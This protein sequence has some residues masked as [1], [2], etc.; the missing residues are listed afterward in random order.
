MQAEEKAKISSV[1]DLLNT[2]LQMDREGVSRHFA[3]STVVDIHIA[4]TPVELIYNGD[5]RHAPMPTIGM[6][7]GILRLLTDHRVTTVMRNAY[8]IERFES[9]YCGDEHVSEH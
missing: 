4:E 9:V 6:L 1:V 2:V 5:D 8:L 7:N 3:H